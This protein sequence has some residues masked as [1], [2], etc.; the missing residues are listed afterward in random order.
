MLTTTEGQGALPRYFAPVF[1]RACEMKA[2]RITFVLPDGRRFRADGAEPGPVA[3]LHVHD[4]SL[5]ARLIREGQLGFAEAYLDGGWSTPDLQAFMD[6]VRAAGGE[7][8]DG[9]P[10]IGLLRLLERGRH[11][12][13]GNT[14]SQTTGTRAAPMTASPRSRCSRLWASADQKIRACLEMATMAGNDPKLDAAAIIA[15]PQSWAARRGDGPC[16]SAFRSS[17]RL[18][19]LRCPKDRP[20]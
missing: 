8:Y 3:E 6:L 2:G 1:A 13:R 14:R 10:G 12:L 17:R 15:Q 9:F 16:R 7:I 4:S 11:A 20:I 18:P 19:K 5:F